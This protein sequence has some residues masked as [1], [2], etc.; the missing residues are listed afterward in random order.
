M[1]GSVCGI[2][3]VSAHAIEPVVRLTICSENG[4][5]LEMGCA[6]NCAS[7]ECYEYLMKAEE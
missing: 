1:D 2:N 7:G 4:M 3:P 6:S 5:C